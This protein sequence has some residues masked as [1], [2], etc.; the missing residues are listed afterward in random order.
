MGHYE[1]RVEEIARDVIDKADRNKDS[2]SETCTDVVNKELH[3]N[4]GFSTTVLSSSD[5]NPDDFKHTIP[6]PAEDWRKV[7]SSMAYNVLRRD[8]MEKIDEMLDDF[9][10]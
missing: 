9:E 3:D 5:K 1:K 8:V 2:L 10:E 6:D 4:Y 7:V